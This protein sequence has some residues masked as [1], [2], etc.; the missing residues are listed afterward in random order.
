MLSY[1]KGIGCVWKSL[2]YINPKNQKKK[3]NT[4]KKKTTK[5]CVVS[6][7]GPLAIMVKGETMG[8][9]D[10]FRVSSGCYSGTKSAHGGRP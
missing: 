9:N 8:S 10:P 1:E 4:V 5:K 6:L 3:K 7:F 2:C